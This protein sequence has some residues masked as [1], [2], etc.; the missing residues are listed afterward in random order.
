MTDHREA[1]ERAQ[2]STVRGSCRSLTAL[3]PIE[4]NVVKRENQSKPS[5]D[6][7]GEVLKFLRRP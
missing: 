3:S 4:E 5:V 6:F 7:L 2:E 1:E